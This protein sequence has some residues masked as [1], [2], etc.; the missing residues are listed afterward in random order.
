MSYIVIR[1]LTIVFDQSASVSIISKLKFQEEYNKLTFR[2][3][4][5]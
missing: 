5:R 3:A 4:F 2:L 1:Y